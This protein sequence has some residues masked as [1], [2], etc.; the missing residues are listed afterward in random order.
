MKKAPISSRIFELVPI[1]FQLEAM[2]FQ[3]ETFNSSWNDISSQLEQLL[4]PAG[5][6]LQLEIQLEKHFSSWNGHIWQKSAES[7]LSSGRAQRRYNT[8]EAADHSG[9]Q[10]Q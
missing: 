2:P 7:S 8:P 4:T 3:L 9:G 6:L 5:N 10:A 1:P